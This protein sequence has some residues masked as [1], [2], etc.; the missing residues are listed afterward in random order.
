MFFSLSGEVV[1]DVT[2]GDLEILPNPPSAFFSGQSLGDKEDNDGDLTNRKS[3]IIFAGDD[4]ELPREVVL[5]GSGAEITVSFGGSDLFGL[6]DGEMLMKVDLPGEPELDEEQEIVS[7][8]TDPAFRFG[9]DAKT[10]RDSDPTRVNNVSR[11]LAE[12]LGE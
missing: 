6:I 12:P 11:P 8:L 1:R 10:L 5:G 2:V 7:L 3:V 4:S 9:T